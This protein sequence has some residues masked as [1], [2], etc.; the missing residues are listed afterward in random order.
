MQSSVSEAQDFWESTKLKITEIQDSPNID[1]QIE[2]YNSGD[3]S[4][5]LTGYYLT[6][7]YGLTKWYLDPL[8]TISNKG[9]G[10]Y[11]T[12]PGQNNL[13]DEGDELL[14][15]DPFDF[16]LDR[17][18]YG[19]SG[20]TPDPLQGESTSRY[21][22]GV[23]YE[24][25]WT[26]ENVPTFGTDNT[27]VDSETNPKVVL[28]EVLFNPLSHEAFIELKYIGFGASVDLLGWKIVVDE[29]YTIGSITLNLQYRYFVLNE[30]LAPSLF[31]SLTPT[32][33]NV[34][35]YN[36]TGALVDMVGWNS[37]HDLDGS[38]MRVP[39]GEGT[40][41]G[42]ND[43]SSISAGWQFSNEPSMALVNI[44]ADSEDAADLGDT[45]SFYLNIS[46][47]GDTT[48]VID[49]NFTSFVDGLLGWWA[50]DLYF[51]DGSWI[52]L[53][54]TDFDG[55]L[56]VGSVAPQTYITIIVTVTVPSSMPIGGSNIIT[57]EVFSSVNPWAHDTTVLTAGSYPHI[58]AYKSVSPQ[59][60]YVDGGGAFG[61]NPD[62]A[63]LTINLT[64]K[65]WIPGTQI[66][67]DVMFCMDRSSSMMSSDPTRERVAGARYYTDLLDL[68]A[69][70][71]IVEFN[72]TA[73]MLLELTDDYDEVW[74]TL[75]SIGQ[76]GLTDMSLGLLL[77]IDELI[78][79]GNY[80]HNRVI[81]LLTDGQNNYAWQDDATLD[82]AQ[83]AADNGIMIFTIGL[84]DLADEPILQQ[85]AA[86]TGGSYYFSPTPDNLMEIFG[87]IAEELIMIAGQDPDPDDASPLLTDVLPSYI[88]YIPGTFIDPIS[89]DPMD[90]TNITIDG[91]GNTILEWNISQIAIG[92]T[93]AVSFEIT[94]NAI[95][96]VETNLFGV[97]SVN[98]TRYLD[99]INTTSTNDT[100]PR[101]W[102]NVLPIPPLPPTLYCNLT[103]NKNDIWLNWTQPA[104]PTD[105]YLLYRSEDKQGFDF[106]LS[107]KDTSSDVNPTTGILDPQNLNWLDTGAGL[108][109][110]PSQY[111]YVVRSVEASGN[112]SVTSNTVGK[113]T[114]EFV[115]GESAFSLPLEP[116]EIN[117]VDWYCDD[118]PN[119]D[120]IKWADPI[121]QNW[122]THYKS[123]APGI[124]DSDVVLGEGYE[125]T[126]TS[127]T[128][129]TFCG[130]PGTSI[131]YLEENFPA[132][133]GL[134][135]S[136]GPMED[137][138]E[139]STFGS[140]S[141]GTTDVAL[142]DFDSDGKPDVVV[143]NLGSW[144]YVYF[145]DGDGTFDS[146]FQ[147]LGFGMDF[148]MCVEV[149][150]VN[151]DTYLDIV[152]GNM[153]DY[154]EVFLGNGD[155]T[156]LAPIN[157]GLNFVM[158]L[159]IALGDV[160][161]DGDL[162]IVKA[163]D[164]N[165]NYVYLGDGDGTF[166]TTSYAWGTGVDSTW[167]VAIGDVDKNNALDIAAGNYGGQ[168]VVYMGDGDGT[169]DTT[170]Y[171][172]GTGTDA[173]ASVALADLNSDLKLD[174]ITGNI[175][176]QDVI[177][178]GD[179][180]GTFDTTS[181][182]FGSGSDYTYKVIV[183]DMNL[184]SI[185]DIICGNEF[186]GLTAQN[187]IYYGEGDGSFVIS[188]IFGADLDP[189]RGVAVG[190]I[191]NDTR[192]DIV[193]GNLY[194]QNY[195]FYPVYYYSINLSWNPVLDPDLDRYLIYRSD[196]R[197]GLNLLSLVPQGQVTGTLYTDLVSI[198][199]GNEFYYMVAAVSEDD[200][201]GY[202]SSYSLG[203]W[204]SEYDMGYG[205][206]GL[207]L[208][209]LV[210]NT[211]DWYCD[212][213]NST[214]G[215][216]YYI[217]NEQR[218][219][220]HATR[221]P[222]GAYDPFLEIADGYQ[223]STSDSTKYTYNYKNDY[224]EYKHQQYAHLS[225]G[226]KCIKIRICEI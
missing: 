97:S 45:M 7:D 46:N 78:D 223:L 186:D 202:N 219:S 222:A 170:S 173:T 75:G 107:W 61:F 112:K 63:T 172:F 65:G 4:L 133:S 188:E 167:G 88:D 106:S 166:D 226:N 131:R 74:A 50:I 115:L 178:L 14:L 203:I 124:S 92:E 57:L 15:Y 183:N 6:P 180:D 119:V 33:D 81:I 38:A 66:S 62:S 135:L 30:P 26:R 215:M 109:S 83:R 36:A 10:V 162:D 90:P 11:V 40:Y 139:N 132:P 68:P 3:S 18:G 151:N 80:F 185:P 155:G 164:G 19:T 156:F 201:I 165:S 67:Q 41:E 153:M 171:D 129:Y 116:F 169:F 91:F 8:G 189:T 220:W 214:V 58:E 191:N 118:I 134:S 5:D 110:A 72:E 43:T 197:E 24:E 205:S 76:D 159:D 21:F 105:H 216:N 96:L 146:R 111:Y 161:S 29:A 70:A 192:E 168:N 49:I 195:A 34:Y 82:Q 158:C 87:F 179:G 56:D 138:M 27:V 217:I 120:Q 86:I 211:L 25:V 225:I 20:F 126:V 144:N 108:S 113:W 163:N 130:R 71:G 69:R 148:S 98:Y 182:D 142:G 9:Y 22:S 47:A 103:A 114:R 224:K 150:D 212:D 17:V 123:D 184:D 198:N 28:N 175:G 143:V 13:G 157:F 100:L 181:Y 117:S 79:N 32:G 64:G 199:S 95:G 16:I 122:V 48:D 99:T 200:I 194:S 140:G 101:V 154:S 121:S 42:Y 176:G 152:V 12:N 125:I 209:P 149:G 51:G 137:I 218:W 55:L 128:F 190:D 53:S 160:N 52:P 84:G 210:L 60:I 85:I 221:M 174:I 127:Q 147:M 102:L 187:F 1:E 177:Y 213:I 136:L 94:S 193:T 59:S 23:R 208:E 35:L 104:T 196:D 44:E 37:P 207:P 204:F 141:D 31:G 2:I 145:G 89:G 206:F 77:S 93:W 54:D 73:R 39:E